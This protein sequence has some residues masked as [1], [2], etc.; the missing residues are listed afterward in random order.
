LIT[1]SHRPSLFKY[2]KFLVRF[3]GEGGWTFSQLDTD[4]EVSSKLCLKL[5]LFL[6]SSI[7]PLPRFPTLNSSCQFKRKSSSSRRPSRRSLRQRPAWR[8][9]RGCLAYRQLPPSFI[10]EL[11]GNKKIKKES[12]LPVILFF[13][14]SNT[15]DPWWRCEGSRQGLFPR[16]RPSLTPTQG[17]QRNR[18]SALHLCGVFIQKCLSY[19]LES[20]F[21]HQAGRGRRT[22]DKSCL[23]GKRG[24][25]EPTCPE[26]KKK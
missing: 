5:S 23:R 2:H 25:L 20:I 1:V 13:L 7:N 9:S 22:A 10:V 8:K 14:C 12:W 16:H 26:V 4:K 24:W 21:S 18:V 17:L 11:W 3:D 6:F 19:H 15:R